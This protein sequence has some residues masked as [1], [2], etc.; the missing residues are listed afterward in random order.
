MKINTFRIYKG[1]L[2]EAEAEK[3]GPVALLDKT[4]SAI[5]RGICVP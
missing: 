3:F 1:V 2:G 5:I 4:S